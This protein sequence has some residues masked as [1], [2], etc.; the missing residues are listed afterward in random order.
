MAP[1]WLCLP[2]E[3]TSPTLHPPAPRTLHPAP[4]FCTLNP[5]MPSPSSPPLPPHSLLTMLCWASQSTAGNTQQQPATTSHHQPPSLQPHAAAATAAGAVSIGCDV[6][7]LIHPQQP[8]ALQLNRVAIV[9]GLG[10]IQP[11][12]SFSRPSAALT[13]PRL[14]L[15]PTCCPSCHAVTLCTPP[16]VKL[17]RLVECSMQHARRH[18]WHAPRAFVSMPSCGPSPPAY[19]CLSLDWEEAPLAWPVLLQTP[20]QNAQ[21]D[22]QLRQVQTWQG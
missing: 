12:E 14:Q 21:C 7:T 8:A 4:S 13:A 15:L 20:P 9:E 11:A 18:V 1:A 6:G 22:P 10:S 3:A 17:C 16:Q 19:T 2:P 5:P